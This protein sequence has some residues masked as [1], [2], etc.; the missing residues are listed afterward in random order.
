M[1]KYSMIIYATSL[2]PNPFTP[3]R[4]LTLALIYYSGYVVLLKESR[5]PLEPLTLTRVPLGTL[6]RVPLGLVVLHPDYF[7]MLFRRLRHDQNF[8]NVSYWC[9]KYVCIYACCVIRTELLVG[10]GGKSSA[11]VMDII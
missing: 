5:V 11:C 4:R 1:A 8:V 7:P 9:K 2:L 10:K 6:T 3:S